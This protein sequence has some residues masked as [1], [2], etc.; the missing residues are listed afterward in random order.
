M[1]RPSKSGPGR[2]EDAREARRKAASASRNHRM[3]KAALRFALT[4]WVGE[5]F[6]QI[7]DS[8]LRDKFVR[9]LTEKYLG[10]AERILGVKR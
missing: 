4:D 5:K 8:V 3:Y 9:D 7:H 2:S 10:E 1:T 6:P